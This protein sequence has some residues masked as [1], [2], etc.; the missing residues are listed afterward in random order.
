MGL[1]PLLLGTAMIGVPLAASKPDPVQPALWKISDHD[2]TIYLFGTFHA[3]DGSTHWFKDRVKSAFD[4]SDELVLETILPE[5]AKLSEAGSASLPAPARQMARSGSL[6][7]ATRLVL[8]AG[9]ARGMSSKL[10]ADAELR[11]AAEA[12]GKGVGGL[13]T[14][15]FQLNMFTSLPASAAAAAA[16]PPA[17]QPDARTMTAVSNVLAQLQD[18]WNRGDLS[19]FAPMLEQMRLQSPQTY[20]AM[21]ADRNTRWAQWIAGRMQQPGTVFVAVGAGHLAGRDSVQHKLAGLGVGTMR[22]N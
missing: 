19:T 5:P 3:L 14:L 15:E 7:A 12:T 8:N 13:E 10:G 1:F 18:A 16:P 4:A 9:Q 22:I 21:F 20:Q 6:L 11:H 17:A 2:T